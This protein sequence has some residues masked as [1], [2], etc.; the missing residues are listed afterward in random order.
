MFQKLNRFYADWRDADGKRH[1]KAFTSAV[2]ALDFERA[3]QTA[4][5]TAK[6]K[7]AK[8]QGKTPLPAS[9]RRSLSRL[10]RAKPS[11]PAKTTRR[12]KPSSSTP[13]TSSR[14]PSL[15]RKSMR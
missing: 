13:D 5:A 12:P 7:K 8:A 9:S 10:E 14:R 3:V 4:S 2:L 6:P 1:R 15:R 11:V